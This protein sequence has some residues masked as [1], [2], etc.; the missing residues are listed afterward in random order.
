MARN[1]RKEAAQ[2][3][4][5]RKV[6]VE[7]LQRRVETINQKVTAH[8]VLRRGGVVLQSEGEEQFS[9]PFHGADNK[10]SARVYPENAR[11]R[12]HAWCFVC[13]ERWDVI[14]LW[15]KFNPA[16]GKT[17]SRVLREIEQAFGIV[18]PEMPSEASLGGLAPDTSLEAFDVLYRAAESRLL[19]AREAYQHLDDMVGYL[20]AGQVL[21]KVR[22]H[23][24]SRRMKPARGEEILRQLLERIALKV[25]S[26]PVG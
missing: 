3:D 26:C 13:Q 10:P 14:S 24:E 23:V 2:E 15:K 9:C 25:R 18:T 16:E 11:G 22:H 7:W 12:S 20:S 19:G 1:Y 4:S 6:W 17:F 21:D 8:D 5:A